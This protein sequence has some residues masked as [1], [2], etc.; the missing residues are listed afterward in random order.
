MITEPVSEENECNNGKHY[1]NSREYSR[2]PCCDEIETSFGDHTTPYGYARRHSYS[3]EAEYGLRENKGTDR[4]S[5]QYKYGVYYARQY[6]SKKFS[7][8]GARNQMARR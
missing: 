1:G 4:E 2:P 6:V 3:K 5:F 8:F 7:P